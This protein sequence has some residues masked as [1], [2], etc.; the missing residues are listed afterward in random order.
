MN[1]GMS[2]ETNEIFATL[3]DPTRRTIFE[4]LCAEGELT[5]RVLTDQAGVSS[6]GIGGT[7]GRLITA[8]SPRASH[9]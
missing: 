9:R 1:Y 8:P 4:R 2:L 7:D 6:S 3:A 5:V